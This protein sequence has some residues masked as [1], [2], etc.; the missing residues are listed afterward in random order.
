M[1]HPSS[2]GWVFSPWH[3]L[4]KR[5]L[6][7]YIV[8]CPPHHRMTPYTDL[9]QMHHP[10]CEG[11]C[12]KQSRSKRQ[13]SPM[14]QRIWGGYDFE[15]LPCNCWGRCLMCLQRCADWKAVSQDCLL[16]TVVALITAFFLLLSSW[17]DSY[18]LR[19]YLVFGHKSDLFFKVRK[20]TIFQWAC[21]HVWMWCMCVFILYFTRGRGIGKGQKHFSSFRRQ[22]MI[23]RSALEEYIPFIRL[24]SWCLLG[25]FWSQY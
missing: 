2:Y 5:T 3:P 16:W 18:F 13:Q 1:L 19:E 4:E 8:L 22:N 20:M 7:C 6:S 10:G 14:N 17:V 23:E 25:H 15:S 9:F 21:E 24:I 11:T 12:Q